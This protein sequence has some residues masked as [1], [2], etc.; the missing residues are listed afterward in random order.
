MQ[1]FG[2]C[3]N[4]ECRACRFGHAELL[5]DIIDHWDAKAHLGERAAFVERL[6]QIAKARE[7]RVSFV[8]GDVHVGGV[9]RMYTRPKVS[10]AFRAVH[11]SVRVCVPTTYPLLQQGTSTLSREISRHASSAFL[12][13]GLKLHQNGLLSVS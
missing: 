3:F 4:C 13:V 5:D 6:Q 1:H 7:V 10:K 12:H 2:C 11:L 9:G 8:S